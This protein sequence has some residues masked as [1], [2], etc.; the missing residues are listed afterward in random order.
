M[1]SNSAKNAAGSAAKKYHEALLSPDG[2]H[3]LRYLLDRGLTQRTVEAFKLGLV[4]DPDLGHEAMAGR[5]S[6]PYLRPSCTLAIRFRAID[7]EAKLKYTQPA[8]SATYMFN[9]AALDGGG[10]RLFIAE[11][12]FD[13]M[14][15]TQC[16]IPCIGIAGSQAWKPH[17]RSVLDGYSELVVFVD[18]DD[19]GA[20]TGFAQKIAADMDNHGVRALRMPE[21]HDVN[22]AFQENG[23]SWLREYAGLDT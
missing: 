12:E 20:G 15:A 2:E 14:I 22:S 10:H 8:G 4:L 7:P 1:P 13:A 16:G 17:F 6:I 21:G 3:G 9:T 18:A 5:I 23:A 11:G 19:Q